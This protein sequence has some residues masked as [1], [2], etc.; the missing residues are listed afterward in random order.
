MKT[1]KLKKEAANLTL[2]QPVR[3]LKGKKVDA[4]SLK[5]KFFD[6]DVNVPLIQQVVTM[7]RANRR[8]GSASCKT[9]AQV[10][11]GGKKPW[12]QK[13]TGRARTGSIRNPLWR[14]GGVIFGPHPRDYSY[15]LPQKLRKAAF[16]SGLNEKLIKDNMIIVDEI[17]LTSPKTKEFHASLASLGV[18]DG[19][20]AV[21]VMEKPDN[22]TRLASRNIPKVSVKTLESINAM[23]ILTH[24]KL[25]IQQSAL[26][27]LMRSA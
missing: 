3:N 11:G 24:K 2:E 13:G 1:K 5:G 7:Y 20:S 8:S 6:G 4:I 12:R 26:K 16:R 17:K 27:N 14:G 23:D 21:V 19:E 10:S 18:K 15:S 22:N 25:V 9:K